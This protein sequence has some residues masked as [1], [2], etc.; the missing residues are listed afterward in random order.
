MMKL[1]PNEDLF[2]LNTK[3][4]TLNTSTKTTPEGY[5]TDLTLPTEM[6]NDKDIWYTT[7]KRA[8]NEY[9]GRDEKAQGRI[10]E[11]NGESM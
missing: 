2:R 6:M 4:Q 3:E 1:R 7:K 10:V 8:K 11:R 9:V 5:V